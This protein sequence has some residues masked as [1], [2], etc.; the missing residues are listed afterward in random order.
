MHSDSL[1][2]TVATATET[3]IEIAIMELKTEQLSNEQA[4][5]RFT[6]KSIL[7]PGIQPTSHS[8]RNREFGLVTGLSN[9]GSLL[10]FLDR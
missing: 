6:V 4:S 9:W 5:R 3:E 2:H 7:A 10:F 1:K 8:S